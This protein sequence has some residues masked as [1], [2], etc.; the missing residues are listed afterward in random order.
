LFPFSFQFFPVPSK[1]PSPVRP[2]IPICQIFV[3]FTLVW[4]VHCSFPPQ[5]FSL[6]SLR[7]P[8]SWYP[9]LTFF[10]FYVFFCC[11]ILSSVKTPPLFN[12]LFC[13]K[14]SP[15]PFFS[16]S[17]PLRHRRIL[18]LPFDPSPSSFFFPTQ[19]FFRLV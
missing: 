19:M 11:W 13:P 10:F 8:H 5:S 16:L 12:L 17:C 14:T 15:V 7:G 18:S 2:S 1:I 9:F 4:R 3:S 6:P